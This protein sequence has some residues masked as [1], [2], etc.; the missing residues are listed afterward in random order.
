MTIRYP[1]ALDDFDMHKDEETKR[2]TPALPAH[3]GIVHAINALPRET[4]IAQPW[5]IEDPD[6]Y[7]RALCGDRVK[8]ILPQPLSTTDPDGCRECQRIQA[9]NPPA[10]EWED[11]WDSPTEREKSKRAAY[12]RR[13]ALRGPTGKETPSS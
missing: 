4:D 11:F 8:V 9:M 3:L 1:A 10:P 2:F 12:F 5:F 13:H 6:E 7:R